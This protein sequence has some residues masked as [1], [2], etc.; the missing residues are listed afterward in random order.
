MLACP[1]DDCDYS[2]NKRRIDDDAMD[3]L[4]VERKEERDTSRLEKTSELPIECPHCSSRYLNQPSLRQ[5]IRHKHPDHNSMPRL[6]VSCPMDNC[7]VAGLRSREQLADHCR[8][9]H[10]EAGDFELILRSFTSIA[11]FEIETLSSAVFTKDINQETRHY[12]WCSRGNKTLL[13]HCTQS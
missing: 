4:R 3:A 13:C 11:E 5:H 8:I 10:S 2:S 1:V 6:N 9:D 12:F 7:S